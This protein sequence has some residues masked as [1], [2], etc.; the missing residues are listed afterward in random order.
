M[1]EPA[2]GALGS[3][4]NKIREGDDLASADLIHRYEPMLRRV[5]RVTGVI[6][7]LQSEEDSQDLVQSVFMQVV[8]NLRQGKGEFSNESKFEAYLRALGRNWLRDRLRRVQAAKRNRFR[9]IDGEAANL[10]SLPAAGLSP[11]RAVELQDQVAR[12]EACV[13]RE[14]FVLLQEREDGVGW[15]ELAST[16]GL[17]PDALRKRVERVRRRIRESLAASGF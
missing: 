14:D 2:D 12:V 15:D 8:S 1:S 4:L 13:P 16:R 11:S 3:L 9:T 10:R 5:L 6:R 7:W 17:S